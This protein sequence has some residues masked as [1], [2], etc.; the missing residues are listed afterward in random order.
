ME[1]GGIEKRLARRYN[2]DCEIPPSIKP[3]SKVTLKV[4][5]ERKDKQQKSKAA[6]KPTVSATGSVPSAVLML[7][8]SL[9]S[10]G[11]RERIAESLLKGK[12]PPSPG[13]KAKSVRDLDD[14]SSML[15]SVLQGPERSRFTER[16]FLAVASSPVHVNATTPKEVHSKELQRLRQLPSKSR[17]LYS[18]AGKTLES[19]DSAVEKSAKVI[20]KEDVVKKDAGMVKSMNDWKK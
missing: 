12:N 5:S 6:D 11:Q 15:T 3:P 13:A 14:E 18:W 9:I 16:S 4:F 17:E 19:A 1:K 10:Y 2:L 20:G 7:D 8:D